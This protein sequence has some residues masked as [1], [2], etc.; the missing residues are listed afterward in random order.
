MIFSALVLS[1]AAYSYGYHG[2]K[3]FHHNNPICAVVRWD[4]NFTHKQVPDYYSIY[5][6]YHDCYTDT[7]E[8]YDFCLPDDTCPIRITGHCDQ[9]SPLKA[10]AEAFGSAPYY[11][12]GKKYNLN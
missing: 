6:D 8:V 1:S 10:I 5:P 2:S 3:G 7:C 4:F 9:D 12:I 11:V